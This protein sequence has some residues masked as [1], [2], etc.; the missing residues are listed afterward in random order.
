MIVMA[1]PSK[2]SALVKSTV[3][4]FG[5]LDILVNNAGI[6]RDGLLMRMSE[7][8]WDAVQ[9]TN[10]RGTPG[11]HREHHQDAFPRPV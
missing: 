4:Q 2:T 10:L 9:N 3:E 6:T 8:D 7:D 5:G 1:H 11:Q